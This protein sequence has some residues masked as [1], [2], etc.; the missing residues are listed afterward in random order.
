MA[1]LPMPMVLQVMTHLVNVKLND[2]M[3]VPIGQAYVPGIKNK[4]AQIDALPD[5]LKSEPFADELSVWD[6]RHDAFHEAGEK[7]LDGALSC[8]SVSA[9]DKGFLSD[10]KANF[11]PSAAERRAGYAE[12]ADVARQRRGLLGNYETQLKAW[13]VAPGHTLYDWIE[14]MI[15]AGEKLHLLLGQRA[16]MNAKNRKDAMRLRGEALGML[17]DLRRGIRSSVRDD[18]SLPRDLEARLFGLMDTLEGMV[19]NKSAASGEPA[20]QP[21][22]PVKTP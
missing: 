10:I 21:G 16:D 7:Y 15:G 11:M 17:R 9:E 5:S 3:S 20:A 13:T 12:E 6:D 14:G 4:I 1:Y 18:A 22:E 19:H 2:L 8:P